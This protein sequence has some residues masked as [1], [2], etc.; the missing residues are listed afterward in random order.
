MLKKNE[1][2]KK[3]FKKLKLFL[4]CMTVCLFSMTNSYCQDISSTATNFEDSFNFVDNANYSGNLADYSGYNTSSNF[5][6][7]QQM[8]SGVLRVK[9]QYRRHQKITPFYASVG[10]VVTFEMTFQIQGT[11]VA[12]ANVFNF[13]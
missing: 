9:S 1:I 10:N 13:G 4:L 6:Y 3:S 5:N 7:H 2:K 11:L 12:N 8:A